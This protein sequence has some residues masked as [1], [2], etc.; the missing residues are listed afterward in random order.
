MTNLTGVFERVSIWCL[1]HDE[2]EKMEIVKNAETMKSPFFSC[3][4]CP[5]RLNIDDYEG[6][7][8]KLMDRMAETL[9]SGDDLMGYKFDYRGPRQKISCTVIKYTD[10]EIRI[11]IINRTVLR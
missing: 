1:N 9:L 2:P 11:G 10:S 5:D 7:V 4:K 3:G 8:N 6:I